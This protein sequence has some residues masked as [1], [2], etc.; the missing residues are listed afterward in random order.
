MGLLRGNNNMLPQDKVGFNVFTCGPKF[1][2]K[3][4]FAAFDYINIL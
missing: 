4:L 3:K 2:I 1:T